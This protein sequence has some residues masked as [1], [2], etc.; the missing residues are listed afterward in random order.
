M[1]YIKLK[2]ELQ[3]LSHCNLTNIESNCKY[4]PLRMHGKTISKT[5]EA[6]TKYLQKHVG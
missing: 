5:K 2:L 6:F 4:I 1:Y 3:P